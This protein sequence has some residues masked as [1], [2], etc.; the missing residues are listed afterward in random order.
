[1]NWPTDPFPD[2]GSLNDRRQWLL[3]HPSAFAAAKSLVDDGILFHALGLITND[4]I[5]QD[6]IP[7]L[8]SS[9]PVTDTYH[10]SDIVRSELDVE[11]E[12]MN[13]NPVGLSGSWSGT[14]FGP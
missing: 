8:D 12:Q 6:M 10:D 13:P 14:T 1:M 9:A 4:S 3:R 5:V 7:G 2:F 11:Q